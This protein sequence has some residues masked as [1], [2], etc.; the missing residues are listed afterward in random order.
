MWIVLLAFGL[1]GLVW[2]GGL[3]NHAH[4]DGEQFHTHRDLRGGDSE[5][6]GHTRD[7]GHDHGPTAVPRDLDSLAG[8]YWTAAFPSEGFLHSHDNDHAS[9]KFFPPEKG[10]VFQT[11]LRAL[12][13]PLPASPDPAEP[14]VLRSRGPPFLLV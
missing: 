6:H 14:E 3:V 10:E 8:M 9:G 13:S 4:T 11:P 12:E 5:P 7:H 1:D 2:D